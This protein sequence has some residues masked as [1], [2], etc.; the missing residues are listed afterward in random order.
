LNTPDQTA[1]TRRPRIVFIDGLPGSGKSTA[2]QAIGRRWPNCRVFLE[3]HPGHPLLV[4]TPDAKGAAFARIHEVHSA[5]SFAAAALAALAAFLASAEAGICYVFESHPLQSTVRVLAQLDASETA[6][7]QFWSQVQDRLAAAEVALVYFSEPDPRQALGDIMR[8]RGPVW[9]RYM[10]E[11]C[12]QYPWMQARGLS[13]RAGVFEL[14][15][16]YQSLLERL[17]AAWRFELLTLAGRPASYRE[18]TETMLTWL[19]QW[20][21]A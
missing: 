5:S 12:D 3:S 16:Q 10:V 15:G 9:E 7:L 19:E 8:A 18:R 1:T 6:V 2:A 21:A 14:I 13:G 4:G 20:A 11:A 17:V